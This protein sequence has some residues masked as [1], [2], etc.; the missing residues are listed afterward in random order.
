MKMYIDWNIVLYTHVCLAKLLD[1]LKA[2]LMLKQAVEDGSGAHIANEF[3]A[4]L[5]Y[6]VILN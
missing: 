3:A 5:Q 2:N 6:S 1:L 4:L